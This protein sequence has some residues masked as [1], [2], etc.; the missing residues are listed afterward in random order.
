MRKNR[1]YVSILIIIVFTVYFLSIGFSAISVSGRIENIMASVKPQ[2]LV[3]ITNVLTSDTTNSGISNSED[4][5]KN[6]INA[7]IVLPNASSTITYKVNVTVYLES[8]MKISNITLSDPS[9]DY[10][11]SGYTLGNALCNSNND[12]NLGATDEIYLTIKY[13]EGMYDSSNTEHSFV[14][15]FKFEILDYV[16]RIGT[17]F[18]ESLQ[19]AIDDVPDNTKTTIVML[20]NTSES[21]TILKNKNILFDFQNYT[22]SNF[23]ENK[24][25]DNYGTIEITNGIITSSA[26]YAVMDNNPGGKVTISG[27]SLVA[28]GSRGAIYNT[29]GTLEI[30]GNAII[31]SNTS[32]RA[33]IQNLNNGILRIY[34]GS[35]ISTR[36]NAIDNKSTFVLGTKDGTVSSESPLLQG[37]TSGIVSTTNFSFYD[38]IVKGIENPISD[39]TKITDKETGYGILYGTEPIGSSIYNTARLALV[40]T[41]TFDG[42][43]GTVTEASRNIA[44]GQKLGLLPIPNRTDYYFEG[45][46]D[47][48]DGGNKYDKDTVVSSDTNLYAHWT[49]L[50][51]AKI[52]KIGDVY[53]STIQDALNDV[54]KNNTETTVVIIRDTVENLTIEK[55]QN[56]VLDLQDYT[57]RNNGVS[58]VIKNNGRLR[59]SNGTIICNTTQ[60]AIN[61]NKGAVLYVTGG[62]I[63]ATGTRQAIYN[64]G[65]TLYISGNP[66]LSS[67]TN[68]RATVQNLNNGT[69]TITG[70]TI[71]SA[72][73]NA[74]ENTATMNIGKKDGIIDASS[75]LIIGR[76]YGINNTKTLN[77]YDGII[78]GVSASVNGKISD[79]ETGS[80]RVDST[81]TIDG[82]VYNTTYFN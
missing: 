60:G 38:G 9:L 51:D 36:K 32:E 39:L 65:G 49:S 18:Y 46:Y 29:G 8:I 71:V 66:Y 82:N 76:N 68:Q 27:G 37:G 56:V 54:P 35:V 15:D 22:L 23:G 72:N 30:S 61:N 69:V 50:A 52:A 21:L 40:Y 20:K 19:E 78:K 70:G 45:W 11:L 25:I 67:T 16:A 64:D 79:T 13:K 3:R 53:Y 31:S 77:I 28:T 4:Y 10:E 34:S 58:N 63:Y 12:C 26:T 43:G 14:A 55:N 2:G 44:R 1:L 48:P 80:T 73:F 17:D 42:N 75:P 62:S 33:T 74:I 7:N 57:L 81:E 6:N 5:N 59:I 47:D 24:L 41:I